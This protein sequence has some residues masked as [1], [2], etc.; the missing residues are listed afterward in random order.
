MS[1]TIPAILKEA[2]RYRKHLRELQSEIDRGPRIHTLQQQK[3]R[4]KEAAHKLAHDTRNK[5][6]L[7]IREDEVSLKTN[8]AQLEKFEKQLN[9]AGSPKEY[10]AKKSEIRQA[11][12]RIAALE[13]IILQALDELDRQTADVPAVEK[14]WSEAQEEFKQDQ[15]DAR[16]RLD[17]LIEEQTLATKQL[18][19]QESLLPADVKSQY[20]RLITRYGADGLAGLNGRSCQQCHTAITEQLKITIQSGKF[21]CCPNC[22]R[23][24]YIA[25]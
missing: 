17:R 25:G 11:Q 10:E 3:L 8:S 13:E 2:H 20:D 19:E 15:A 6:K 21:H 23:G 16:E 5:L 22:G 24:L 12:E 7:K 9:D 14:R 18:A 4:D 1:S